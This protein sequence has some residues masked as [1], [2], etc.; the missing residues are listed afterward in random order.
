[1][2]P[3]AYLLSCWLA[4]DEKGLRT[5]KHKGGVSR[6]LDCARLWVLGSKSAIMHLFSLGS[7]KNA[8]KLR[9]TCTALA[10]GA[11]SRYRT[12]PSACFSSPY[13]LNPCSA[14]SIAKMM[15]ESRVGNFTQGQTEC[16]FR[17]Q[18]RSRDSPRDYAEEHRLPPGYQLEEARKVGEISKMPSGAPMRT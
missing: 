3:C 8:Q 13:F 6:P 15:I 11:H 5:H 16:S 17:L 1:M 9:H 18:C 2:H 7:R 14:W 4:V 12:L 10:C